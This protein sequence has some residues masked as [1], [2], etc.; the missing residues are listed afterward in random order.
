MS[1]VRLLCA[2]GRDQSYVPG[3]NPT[4]WRATGARG[5]AWEGPVPGAGVG[6]S[7]SRVHFLQGGRRRRGKILGKC[8]LDR[9]ALRGN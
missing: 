7:E 1:G 9:C 3:G 2:L 6:N 5:G 4:Q 8:R